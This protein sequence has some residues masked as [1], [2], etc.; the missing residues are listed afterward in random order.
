MTQW[1]LRRI[2]KTHT[3]FLLSRNYTPFKKGYTL[4]LKIKN[5]VCIMML[6]AKCGYIWPRG[7]KEEVK[8]VKLIDRRTDQT[9]GQTTDNG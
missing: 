8:N 2:L 3:L 5:S 6:C 4:Y 1:F 7:S 9:D